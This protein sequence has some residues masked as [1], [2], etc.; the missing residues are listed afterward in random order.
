MF[1]LTFSAAMI[2][3]AIRVGESIIK[4]EDYEEMTIIRTVEVNKANVADYYDE[5]APY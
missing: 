3:K 5:D 1:S 4:E 2:E